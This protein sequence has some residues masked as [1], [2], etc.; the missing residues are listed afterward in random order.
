VLHDGFDAAAVAASIER[1]AL[2]QIS[3][4]PTMLARVL[5]AAPERSAPRTLRCVLLGGGPIPPALLERARRRGFRI[6]A[7][8]GLTEA[9]SQVATTEPGR[10]DESGLPPLS[11]T[12]LR[13]VGA[14]GETLPAGRAGEICV[15]GP[16]VMAGY[17]GRP[18]ATARA[19]REGWLHT[20]DVGEIDAYG[21]LRV[22]D[23][24]DDLIV[25]GGENVYPAEVE[26]ALLA[27][28]DVAE[29]GV[30]GL[31]DT[32]WGQRVVAVVV[33]RRAASEPQRREILTHCA[34]ALA[35][36]KR[37]RDLRFAQALPRTASG[38]LQRTALRDALRAHDAI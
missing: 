33:P 25:S 27:H 21:R 15:R 29:A 2:T 24:R 3:L 37:P 11:A 38:K 30:V 12:E 6:A 16:Q 9:A 17:L 28:P 22:L 31:A 5:D 4:V 23:R 32:D 26:A 8:Y 20:G 35:R 13:T 10:A 19:L 18:D 7:T 1:D 14:G 36:F 34:D